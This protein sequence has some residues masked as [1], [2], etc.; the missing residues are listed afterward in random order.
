MKKRT[1]LLV[2]LAAVLSSCSAADLGNTSGVGNKGD[3]DSPVT[4]TPKKDA[5]GE[6]GEMSAVE[7]L[8]IHY[9]RSAQ[10]YTNW[11]AWVW[12]KLPKPTD[13]KMFMFTQSDG[14]VYGNYTD[15]TL[16]NEP[17]LAGAEE[18]GFLLKQH[19]GSDPTAWTDG[20]RDVSQDRFITVP[21][22]A[23][24]G[25]L[26]IWLYEG[27]ADVMTSLEQALKDKIVSS[28]FLTKKTITTNVIL[29]AD[30]SEI[31]QDMFHL[32]ENGVKVDNK[33]A[34]FSYNNKKI[35]ITLSEEADITK[36]YH[37][38]VDFP[39]GKLTM[40]CGISCFYSD[41]AFIDNFTYY[42][43]DLGV[44]F[45]KEK[46]TTTF[47]LWA[48][49]S[50]KVV[51]N[52]YDSGTPS[53]YQDAPSLPEDEKIQDFPTRKLEMRKGIQGVW[54][55]TIPA[56]LHG[57]YYTYS[58]T[59][60]ATTNEVVDPYAKACGIDGLRG[61]AV[62]FDVI[63]EEMN[64]SEVKRPN[65]IVDATDAT[66][67][68]VHVRDVTID[69]SS[70]VSEKNRGNFLGLT[71][72]GTKFTKNNVTVSTGLDSIKE[73]GV[74]HVQLQPLY[75]YRTVDE[76][77]DDLK[78]NWGY[79][80]LNYNCLEGSYS[81]NP[82]D[83]L[84]RIREFKEMMA[85]FC[86]EGINVNL[87]VVYNHTAVSADSNFE[88]IIPGY[89]HRMTPS[90]EFSDGSGCGNEM[91]TENYMY[92]K[93]VVDSCKFWLGE[94]NVSGFRFDLM[95]LLDTTTMETVYLQC[96]DIY[97]E[98]MVYG[99]PW[100]SFSPSTDT[101]IGTTQETMQGIQ[102][103]GGFNDKFRDAVKGGNDLSKGW[104]QGN[105]S[106]EIV[107]K[108]GQGIY[109]Q[110]TEHLKNPSKTVNYVTCHDN[111]ALFDLIDKSQ[112]GVAMSRKIEQVEQ[113]QA[114]VFFANGIAFMHG[115]EEML[116]TKQAGTEQQIH[117]SYN[118]GDH[119]NRFDYSRKVDYLS[120]YNFMKD[121]IKI[122]NEFKGFRLA[123]NAEVEQAL[124]MNSP[125]SS[126]LLIDYE[127]TY[128]GHTYRVVS[129]AGNSANVSGLSGYTLA[130]ANWNANFSGSSI[131][132]PQNGICVLKK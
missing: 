96:K 25:M 95:Q 59:N 72:K 54:E 88:Y 102:G 89:Y 70:G 45:N 34:Q 11:G 129:N 86:E 30:V 84:V 48:P 131:T 22:E 39:S 6:T 65:R 69:P 46:T 107:C 93:F 62:D 75:D 10:D 105:A 18:I 5:D 118:A 40:D 17:S 43:D 53:A 51:L 21:A 27:V 4:E 26:E 121:A 124:K 19:T 58:V 31:T 24:N 125:W 114:M 23:P 36:T 113:A 64:W 14:G 12:Q 29:S 50:S 28:D 60:G 101:Y 109:G 99:E 117:N 1:L 78:Y 81:T 91:A 15:I 56:Y 57:R 126:T 9:A 77:Y 55:I 130:V 103:V 16:A 80:P 68:E 61:Q 115:G 92:R 94:Y 44:T 42:G 108:I 13:G 82:Y 71:E 111:Y 74:T 120:T 119:V 33:I 20:N 110:F 38:E 83:G 49:I 106:D 87:D 32:Y 76:A 47:K 97:N 41:Q 2:L 132:V 3:L 67:Y 66:I 35:D 63:N 90:G 112:P 7:T 100:K 128:N 73:L 79:D 8:R 52:L 123:T 98:V 116:R 127:I 85:T 122:R 104:I 37:V